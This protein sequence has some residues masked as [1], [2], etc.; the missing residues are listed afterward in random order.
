MKMI[1][2]FLQERLQVYAQLV[3][4]HLGLLVLLLNHVQ[5]LSNFFIFAFKPEVH[6]PNKKPELTIVK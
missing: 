3:F 6:V 2:V 5:H 4:A 1:L